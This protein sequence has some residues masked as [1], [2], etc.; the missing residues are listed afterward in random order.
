[1]ATEIAQDR[2][3]ARLAE[4]LRENGVDVFQWDHG[5]SERPRIWFNG[6]DA[7]GSRAVEIG[8]KYGFPTVWIARKWRVNSGEI[9]PNARWQMELD[10]DGLRTII[11][12]V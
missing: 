4:I 1:M 2:S 12:E 11:T 6:D 10:P 8:Q 3:M 9:H 7:E 5:Y